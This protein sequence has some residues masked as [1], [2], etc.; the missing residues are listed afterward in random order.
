MGTTLFHTA[1]NA[2]QVDEQHV[3]VNEDFDHNDSGIQD[4][5]C[6]KNERDWHGQGRKPIAKVTIYK[7]CKQSDPGE[8]DHGGVK[9][10]HL[11]L[12]QLPVSRNVARGMIAQL[13]ERI[14][15]EHEAEQ[16]RTSAR[17]QSAMSNAYV[18]DPR[19]IAKPCNVVRVKVSEVDPKR[20]R[21]SL[22]MWLDQ[23]PEARPT[24][25]PDD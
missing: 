10:R 14:A 21:I 17:C 12:L 24:I 8:N 18:R 7:G 6:I 3:K 13:M 16:R 5:I 19:L 11:Q 1:P 15:G 20:R 2:V 22:T 23:A 4:A 25:A 9:R